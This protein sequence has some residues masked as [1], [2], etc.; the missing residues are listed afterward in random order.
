VQ[1]YAIDNYNGTSGI[2]TNG[3]KRLLK[4]KRNAYNSVIKA[5]KVVAFGN[6]RHY[7]TLADRQTVTGKYIG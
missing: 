1:L 5:A 6:N 7:H 3:L 2:E 4:K